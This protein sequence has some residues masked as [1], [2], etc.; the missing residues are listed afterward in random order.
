MSL[1]TVARYRAITGDVDTTEAAVT[2]RVELAVDRLEDALD[3]PLES[4]ELTETL[5]PTRD[6]KL[7]PRATPVTDPGD[8]TV[9]GLALKWATPG[10]DM[11]GSTTVDVTYTGGWVERS[12]NPNA[13]NRLPA[14]IE[15]DLAWAAWALLHPDPGRESPVPTGA[16]SV[17][18]GDVGVTFGPNGA[19]PPNRSGITWSRRTLGYRYRV[20][21]GS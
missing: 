16:R 17:Q 19:P 14:C 8:Y 3:R 9:D 21:R 15:E 4:A 7:W 12:A 10:V 11:F 5:T 1:L 18:L 13:T 2:A 20:P 6:G